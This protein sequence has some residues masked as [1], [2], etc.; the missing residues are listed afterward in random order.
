MPNTP[1]RRRPVV[2]DVWNIPN[3]LTMARVVVIPGFLWLLHQA[4]REYCFWA[5]IVFTLAAIT[6]ALDGYLARRMGIESVFGKLLD[7]L[8]DKLIVMASLVWMVPMGRIE[9]AVVVLL[10]AREFGI[11]SLRSVAAS[12]GMVIAAGQDGKMKTALQMIG[13]ICLIA[14]HPYRLQYFGID[15]GVCDLVHVGKLLVYSSLVFSLVSALS[16]GR[17]FARAIDARDENA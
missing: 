6:D 13:I 3:A 9:P 7:P 17:L 16:Y 11:T 8:A 10:L 15:C 1:K 5:A 12:E 4:T 14:G 2:E